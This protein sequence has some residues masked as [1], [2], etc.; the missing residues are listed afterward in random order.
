MFL[1]KMEK[2]N[3]GWNPGNPGSPGRLLLSR[4]VLVACRADCEI[5]GHQ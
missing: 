5:T 4:C 1:D 2:E 3:Y